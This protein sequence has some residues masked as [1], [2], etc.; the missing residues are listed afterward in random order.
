[1]LESVVGGE[2]L[3]GRL[4]IRSSKRTSPSVKASLGEASGAARSTM[5]SQNVSGV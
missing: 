4:A 5:V 2:R 3:L 1:M